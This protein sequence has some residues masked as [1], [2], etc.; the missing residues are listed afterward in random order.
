ML[1]DLRLAFRQFARAPG[2]TAVVLLTLTLGIG[3]CTAIFTVV[4]GVVLKPLPFP[5]SD[6]IL[7]VG[8]VE[9]AGERPNSGTVS[10]V[11]YLDW[12]EQ[13]T[14]FSHLTAYRGS[15]FNFT[16]PGGE[17]Q[18]MIG[19]RVSADYFTVLGVAPALGRD[20]TTADDTEGTERVV[21]L[22]DATW[23]QHFSG[24]PDVLGRTVLLNGE[25]HR[26]I[27][28]MPAELARGTSFQFW[29]PLALTAAEKAPA[30]RGSHYLN[31]LG[32]LKPGVTPEQAQVEMNLLAE[33]LAE[34]YPAQSR[35]DHATAMPYL[36]YLVGPTR[37][38]LLALLAAVGTLLL[39]ACANVANL[40]L[41][42]GTSRARE[43]AVRTALG[44]PRARLVRQLLT[45]SVLLAIGGGALGVLAARWGLDALLWLAPAA[46]PRSGEIALDPTVL[47]VVSLLILLTGL[48]FGLAPAL[49]TT[50]F[51]LVE[52]LKDGSRGQSEDGRRRRVRQTFV[53]A[54]IALSLALLAGAG[55]LLRSFV[56]LQ[57][58]DPGFRHENVTTL[59]VSA[60]PA[61]FDTPAKRVAI[62]QA[63]AGRI[64]A[65]PGVVA[66]GAAHSLPVGAGGEDVFGFALE[67]Q[68]SS[69]EA[70]LPSATYYMA[71]DGFIEAMGMTLVRGRTFT[72]Q[73][74][75]GS[76][77]VVIISRGL[78]ERYFPGVDPIGRRLTITNGPENWREIVGVVRD[79]RHNSLDDARTFQLY[80]PLAQRAPSTLHFAVRTAR[81]DAGLASA[82][83][84]LVRETD[85]DQPVVRLAPMASLVSASVARQRFGVTLFVVF[86]GL[87]LVLATV[88]IY[89]VVSYSVSQ[90]TAEFGV[91]LALGAQ[92]A[93]L[94][95]LVLR[96][97]AR[98]AVLGLGLG[99]LLALAGG[100][101]IA[102]M[103]YETSAHDPLVL[104]GLT[105]LLGLV[106]LLA[107]WL[108]A[109]RAARVD[110][111]VALRAE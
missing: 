85:P 97:A 40:L 1:A 76:P 61:K 101:L 93:D 27:G 17:P 105:A 38:V 33:R 58:V 57:N 54:E 67:G 44:A 39:I 25:L 60:P 64:R 42:R 36:D 37:P 91:R 65:L 102:S 49:Q 30:R 95:R 56:R 70:D 71:G 90:R 2:F 48:G 51:D 108:P 83:R 62:A 8:E 81:P 47:S 82:L 66:A 12:R 96:E 75:A 14:V 109:R 31:V 73:D 110:P 107:C 98:L 13:N 106:V 63:Y 89:G 43:I 22:A 100:R 88:G 46:L 45:E 23:R 52:S 34:Q 9:R 111:M 15:G 50:H 4:H 18:R 32:R 77:P 69:N 28:V 5:D 16:L 21:L 94:H 74:H 35:D 6:R 24:A 78:A 92:T 79:V 103:L 86:S 68:S 11:N 10:P 72:E 29:I 104:G 7:L 26:V 84:T 80:E 3:A 41:A 55:L 59:T 99:L 87:A 53:V 20:F 19:L